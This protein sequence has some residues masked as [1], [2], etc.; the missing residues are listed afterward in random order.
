MTS[1]VMRGGVVIITMCAR[2]TAANSIVLPHPPLRGVAFLFA[3][4]V[5]VLIAAIVMDFNLSSLSIPST[6]LDKR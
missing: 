5:L 3:V 1:S 6:L 2:E 4:C